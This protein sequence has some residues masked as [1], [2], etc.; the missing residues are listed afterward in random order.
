MYF[1]KKLVLSFLYITILQINSLK[2]KKAR[3]SYVET[4]SG[5]IIL[6]SRISLRLI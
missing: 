5:G 2:N 3:Q 4:N 6:A 1:Y